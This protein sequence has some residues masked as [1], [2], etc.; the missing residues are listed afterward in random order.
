MS[1]VAGGLAA[2]ADSAS[3]SAFPMHHLQ[4]WQ[5]YRKVTTST[6]SPG[7]LVLMLYEGAINFLERAMS[8]FEFDDPAQFNGVISNNLLRAQGILNELNASLDLEQGGELALT[9]RRLYDYMDRRLTESNHRK[10]RDGIEE[11][12]ARLGTLR[13]AWREMLS[14][15]AR[16]PLAANGVNLSA[17]V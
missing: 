4:P 16:Y 1:A 13:D 17:C 14:E 2:V 9:L 10:T 15:T 7:Q 5:S 3:L 11:T 8:G 12:I 6:A